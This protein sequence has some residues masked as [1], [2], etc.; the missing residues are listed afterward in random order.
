MAVFETDTGRTKTTHFGAKG[1]DDYTRT[2]DKEQ[3]ARYRQRHQKDLQT[4]DPTRAG[5][6]AYHILWG[7]SK[8][9][10]RNIAAYKSKF[11]L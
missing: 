7:E 4:N 6:L 11:H 5:F 1:M 2:F 3:R 10:T 8:S 9:R